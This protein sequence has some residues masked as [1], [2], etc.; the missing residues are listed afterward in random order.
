MSDG[1]MGKEGSS[2]A[3]KRYTKSHEWV[4]VEGEA[5]RTGLSAFAVGEAGSVV[6]IELP[7]P[8]AEVKKGLPFG[9]LESSK[10]VYD[11]FA[12]VSGKVLEVN[13]AVVEAPESLESAPEET[14]LTVIAPA[15]SDELSSL[16]TLEEYEAFLKERE[17]D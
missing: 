9:V 14:W 15:S 10:S 7:S 11:L 12:P 1:E 4:L 8:G 3:E 2:V 17:E 6:F 13:E 5:V 16:M